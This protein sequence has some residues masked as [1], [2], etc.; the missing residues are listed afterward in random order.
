[1]SLKSDAGFTLVELL[2]V[3]FIIVL[4]SGSVMAGYWSGEKSHAVLRVAQQMTADL[5]YVQNLALAGSAQAEVIPYGYGLY[6]PT[7]GQYLLFYNV[8]SVKTYVAGES[9]ILSNVN[10]TDTTLSPAGATI[11]FVPPD[12][13]TYINDLSSGSQAFTVSSG[14]YSKSVTVYASGKIEVR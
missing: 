1:M 14:S 2:V 8:D 6:A 4:L 3:M 12:P 5:R 11:F 10:L 13:T 7:S 9:V